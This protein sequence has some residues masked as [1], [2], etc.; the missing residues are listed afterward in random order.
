[1]RIITRRV[2][3]STGLK[4]K[5]FRV[6]LK[7]SFT[8]NNFIQYTKTNHFNS[9]DDK[10]KGVLNLLINSIL[11]EEFDQE[12]VILSQKLEEYTKRGI[13]PELPSG[14]NNYTKYGKSILF[15]KLNKIIKR[16]VRKLIILEKDNLTN[17]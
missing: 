16:R 4:L 9:L 1:Q 14:Y 13:I 2:N 6:L 11:S 7:Q 17:N 5:H 15:D 8:I 10:L 3:C 12:N